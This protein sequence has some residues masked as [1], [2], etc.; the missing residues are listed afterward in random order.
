[1]I[2]AGTSS[3]LVAIR[4]TPSLFGAVDPFALPPVRF[5]CGVHLTH[6]KRIA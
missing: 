5:W 4:S 1:M 3:K 6:T 2:S